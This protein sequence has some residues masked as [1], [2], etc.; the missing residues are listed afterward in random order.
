MKIIRSGFLWWLLYAAAVLVPTLAISRAADS[1]KQGAK[2]S[3]TEQ[4]QS[5]LDSLNGFR[6]QK[7]GTPFS[8]FQGLTLDK[9]KGDIKLYTKADENLALG[10]VKLEA[11]VYH[12]F[13]DKFYAVSIHTADREDTLNLLRVAVAA[14]GSGDKKENASD[15]LDQSWLGKTAEAFFNVNPKTE[16][17]S[18]VIRDGQLGSEVEAYREKVTKEAADQ[19]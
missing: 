18:L 4:Q 7:F 1:S 19:L 12:F 5:K 17:G 13:Q 3:A 8:E 2:K 15:D 16:Q 9:D 10:P 11:I 14:F 6:G